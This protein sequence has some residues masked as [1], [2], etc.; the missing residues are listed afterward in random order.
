MDI[1]CADDALRQHATV[2]VR[3]ILVAVITSRLDDDGDSGY[4]VVVLRG[5]GGR[6]EKVECNDIDLPTLKHPGT[7]FKAA[8]VREVHPRYGPQIKGVLE[9]DPSGMDMTG[10]RVFLDQHVVGVGAARAALLVDAYGHQ[11][12]AVL[13]DEPC[14]VVADGLLSE[15]VAQVASQYLQ[16]NA[17]DLAE[18]MAEVYQLLAPAR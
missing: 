8:G 4:A 10:L 12:V 14:R 16:R 17:A 6:L 11:V 1:L 13:R 18:T 9:F 2:T 3:G 7:R 5:D 15:A